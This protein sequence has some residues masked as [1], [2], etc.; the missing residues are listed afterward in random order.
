MLHKSSLFQHAQGQGDSELV[1][2][3]ANK[4]TTAMLG[5]GVAMLGKEHRALSICPRPNKSMQRETDPFLERYG[6]RLLGGAEA[7]GGADGT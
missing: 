2:L 3:G 1:K 5:F 4:Y 6:G 7:E